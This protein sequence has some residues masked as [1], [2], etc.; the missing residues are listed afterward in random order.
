MI[1]K[2]P[3]E[4]LEDERIK[5]SVYNSITYGLNQVCKNAVEGEKPIEVIAQSFVNNV[6]QYQKKSKSSPLDIENKPVPELQKF[7]K[8]V[9]LTGGHHFGKLETYVL[10]TE[11]SIPF[12][13]LNQLMNS[14]EESGKGTLSSKFLGPIYQMVV[15]EKFDYNTLEE[16]LNLQN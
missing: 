8:E 5:S 2:T 13:F 10:S 6:F 4:L 12:T 16:L 9:S 7:W 15:E 1:R 14:A 3:K 11:G